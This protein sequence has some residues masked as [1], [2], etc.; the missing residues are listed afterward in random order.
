MNYDTIFFPK[1]LHF[2][3]AI[4][5]MSALGHFIYVYIYIYL[6]VDIY[7]DIYTIYKKSAHFNPKGV[8]ATSLTPY[9]FFL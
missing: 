7:R 8:T 4:Q 3:T 6:Y 5:W 9:T 1:H 2:I